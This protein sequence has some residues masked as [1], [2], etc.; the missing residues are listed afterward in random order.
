MSGEAALQRV[1]LLA[2]GARVAD[3][4]ARPIEHA[5]AFGGEPLE[6]RT[7][8]HEQHAERIL[9]LLDAGREGRLAHA[10]GLGGMTEMPLARERDHEFELVQHRRA[11]SNKTPTDDSGLRPFAQPFAHRKPEK[12]I[13][14]CRAAAPGE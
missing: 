5:L 14:A 9:E 6:P 13:S 11:G 3:D 12:S 4:A 10:A 1:D 7:A 8:L 2:H